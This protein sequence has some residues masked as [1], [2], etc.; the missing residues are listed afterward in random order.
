MHDKIWDVIEKL[1]TDKAKFYHRLKCVILPDLQCYDS[2]SKIC[3][4]TKDS[5]DD[6][7]EADTS[8]IFEF[9]RKNHVEYIEYLEV[10]DCL[11]HPHSDSQIEAC[12]SGFKIYSLNWRKRDISY[13]MLSRLTSVALGLRELT[14]YPSGNEDILDY[15][16]TKLVDNNVRKAPYSTSREELVANVLLDSK[17]SY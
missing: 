8:L 4:G 3:R 15:W 7:R 1:N 9:L 16:A 6:T 10:P 12:L 13:R 5:N 14:F 2:S 11:I 17:I